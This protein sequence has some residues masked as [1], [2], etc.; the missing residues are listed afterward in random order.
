MCSVRGRDIVLFGF[1][2]ANDLFGGLVI[3]RF[4][5]RIKFSQCFVQTEHAD[6][7]IVNK[8]QCTPTNWR[9]SVIVSS[10]YSPYLEVRHTTSPELSL[11]G[12]AGKVRAFMTDSTIS[13]PTIPTDIQLR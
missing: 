11:I 5:F 6:L 4:A 10:V 8:L 9:R 2:P 13:I 7:C 3:C 1:Q 12:P